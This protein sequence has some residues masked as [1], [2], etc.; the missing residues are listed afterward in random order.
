VE[1]VGKF[2][3]V[4]GGVVG[5]IALDQAGSTI[6]QGYIH[7]FLDEIILIVKLIGWDSD[8]AKARLWN[9]RMVKTFRPQIIDQGVVGII[10]TKNKN[11]HC[12]W[13]H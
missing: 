8:F 5:E 10:L 3:S 2:L 11:C 13:S 12:S 1:A 6:I 4:S 9:A 7:C